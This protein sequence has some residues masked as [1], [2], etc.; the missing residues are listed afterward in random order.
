MIGIKGYVLMNHSNRNSHMLHLF[1]LNIY[2]FFCLLLLKND[3]V[4]DC[5]FLMKFGSMKIGFLVDSFFCE[6]F[7]EL[8]V[9]VHP[10]VTKRS[11]RNWS[12]VDLVRKQRRPKKQL[13]KIF[14]WCTFRRK[15]GVFINTLEAGANSR[16]LRKAASMF[17]TFDLKRINWRE[18]SASKMNLCLWRVGWMWLQFL[19]Q[20]LITY[21]TFLLIMNET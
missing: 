21:S 5:C 4:F 9:A 19:V 17:S 14:L 7:A 20:D 1:F 6:L 10:I 2:I 12:K 18:S 8:F 16:D 15:K 13:E 11:K 3:L